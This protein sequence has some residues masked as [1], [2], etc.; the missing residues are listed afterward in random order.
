MQTSRSS[1]EIALSVWK[2]LL[3]RESLARLFAVRGGWF[4]LL[5][6]PVYHIA[7]LMVIFTI[8]QVRHVGGIETPLWILFGMVAFLVFRRTGTQVS[9]AINS[10]QALFSYRQVKPADAVLVR[11]VLEAMLMVV[12]TAV[13]C[14]GAWIAGYDMRPSD[15]LL[16]LAAFAGLWLLGLGYGLVLSVAVEL[17]PE[18]GRIAGLAM[19]PLYFASGAIFPIASVPQPYQDLLMLNPVAHGLEAARL[20]FAA[21]YHAAPGLSVSYVYGCA[22]V[23][24]FAGLALHRRYATQ[25]I[26]R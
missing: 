19:T 24:M 13:L 8:I 15:P 9:N 22:I 21:Y 6:E 10:N 7:Y 3:I 11:G 4:W 26:G 14:M 17:V 23:L 1:V 20:G 25:V 18:V 5:L 2:A 16:F 12:A